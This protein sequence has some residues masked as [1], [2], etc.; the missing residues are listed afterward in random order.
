MQLYGDSTR[1]LITEKRFQR[2]S[3]YAQ[4]RKFDLLTKCFLSVMINE[5]NPHPYAS[6]G[7]KDAK[8]SGKR[9]NVC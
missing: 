4:E 9:G 3:A 7:S 1:E 5:M 8:I 2:L 6:A